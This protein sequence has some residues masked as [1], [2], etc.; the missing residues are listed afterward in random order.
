M[1]RSEIRGGTNSVRVPKKIFEM[2]PGMHIRYDRP[3]IEIAEFVTGYAIYSSVDPAPMVNWYLPAPAMISVLIDTGPTSVSIRNHEFGPLDKVSLYG[4]TVRAIRTET[5]GGIA[6]GIGISAIGWARLIDQPAKKFLNRIVPLSDVMGQK[7]SAKLFDGLN[8]LNDDA[9]IKP[10]LDDILAPLLHKPHPKDEIIRALT[11]LTVT[12]GVI[13]IGDVS[14]R[15]GLPAHELRRIATRYFGMPP[16][17]LLRRARFLRS[18]IRLVTA[19]R[20]TDL[21]L[22]DKS[23]YDASHFLR[24]ADTFLGTTPRRFL[25]SDTTFLKASIRARAAVLGAPTQALQIP[26]S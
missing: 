26:P 23:Y 12:D 18:F 11:A 17:L 10:L 3:A 19:D 16:K 21:S 13:E 15:L 20:L 25:M 14:E 24:D 6:V 7:L 2:P 9:D 1:V 8:C 22:I 4:P 5:T